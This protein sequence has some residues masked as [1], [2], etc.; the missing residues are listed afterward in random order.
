MSAEQGD[1]HRLAALLALVSAAV[2][3]VLSIDIVFSQFP[4]D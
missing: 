4:G 3:A 2:L 1:T